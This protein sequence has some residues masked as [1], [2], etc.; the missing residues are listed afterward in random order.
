MVTME[1][2]IT[3][4]N[5]TYIS[6]KLKQRY[7]YLSSVFSE[8]TYTSIENFILLQKMERAKQLISTDE[9]TFTEIAYMLKYSS[10]AHFS[11]QFK[12]ITGMTPSTFRRIIKKRREN[13]ANMKNGI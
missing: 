6:D 8:V 10:V 11:N 4:S 7:G 1:E 2:K 5:S 12:G 3:S 13:T 9:L